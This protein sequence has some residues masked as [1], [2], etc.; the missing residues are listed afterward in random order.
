LEIRL[1]SIGVSFPQPAAAELSGHLRQVKCP[2]QPLGWRHPPEEFEVSL[3]IRPRL[4]VHFNVIAE[5]GILLL[6]ATS[7]C[8]DD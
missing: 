6:Q 8:N 7:G 4:Y 1:G 3:M 5:S 2:G